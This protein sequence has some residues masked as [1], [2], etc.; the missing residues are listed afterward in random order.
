MSVESIV[1][2]FVSVF[3][4]RNNER[5]KKEE[6]AHHEMHVAINGPELPHCDSLVKASTANY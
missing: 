6:R 2:S 3:E 5:P 1:E 4:N